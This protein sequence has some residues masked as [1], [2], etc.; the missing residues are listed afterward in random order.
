MPP[1]VQTNEPDREKRP[2]RTTERRAE[3]V[4]RIKYCNT[5][6]DIPFDLKF[7][8]YPFPSTRFIQYN[9]TSLEKNYRYEVLT[10]HDLGVHIDLINRDI[11]QGDGNAVLEGADEKLLEDDMLTPQDSKRSRHHAKS[12]SWLRRSEYISTEQTRFQPQSMEKV[13]AKVGY[14]VKKIFSEETLYMD[15]ES[16]IKAIEKTFEDNK[17]TIEK[18]YSKPGVTPV[19]VMPIFPDFEMWKYPCAQVIFDSDPAP[20]D[21]NIAGQI[22]AMSQAMIRGVMDESGE[23]F[24]AYCLPTEETIQKRRRDVAEGVPYMDE[25]TYEYKMAREYN[26]NVKSK[27]SK[28]YEENYFLVNLDRGQNLDPSH[29]KVRRS[30]TDR[31]QDLG[32]DLSRNPEVGPD[33]RLARGNLDPGLA[34]RNLP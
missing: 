1:T 5:L 9:P 13:E 34:L 31:V 7:I 21:K 3:L 2:Q 22:E 10:E 25:D 27:A 23:Q 15:R 14:N 29:R 33:L 6:P 17:K 20:S 11:Y 8:T 28:G 24:V 4:T 30:R 26:W 12:V 16:Q 18:H 19:E 32:S